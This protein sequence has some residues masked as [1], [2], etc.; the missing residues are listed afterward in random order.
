MRNYE[1]GIELN[2]DF[3]FVFLIPIIWS[4]V[5]GILLDSAERDNCDDIPCTFCCRTLRL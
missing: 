2:R 4:D 3:Y 5:F 1:Q